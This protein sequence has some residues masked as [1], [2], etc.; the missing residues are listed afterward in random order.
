MKLTKDEARILAV[1]LGEAKYDITNSHSH[2]KEQ[3]HDHIDAFEDL[4]KRLDEFS[5][6]YRRTGRRSRDE[7]SDC[8]KRFLNAYFKK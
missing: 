2:T 4:Q 3:A 1:A 8:V 6:D 5:K 7:F